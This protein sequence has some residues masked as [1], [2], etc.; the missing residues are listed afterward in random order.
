MKNLR[1]TA[2]YR[3]GFREGPVSPRA[4]RGRNVGGFDEVL[5]GQ[6]K[7]R[8]K[9]QAKG[10]HLV[11]GDIFAQ[12][13]DAPEVGEQNGHAARGDGQPPEVM[14]TRRELHKTYR[15]CRPKHRSSRRHHQ[16]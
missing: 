3:F 16:V 4:P 9:E 8:H 13:T 11:A 6:Q 1:I 5:L 7:H 2:I 14:A 12:E 15:S 10:Y